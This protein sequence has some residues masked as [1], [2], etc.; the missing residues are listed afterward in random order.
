MAYNLNVFQWNCR[1]L[2]AN[3]AY[4]LEF[5]VNS[6]NTH[7]I[8]CL[9]SVNM[10]F[11]EL[12]RLE[13]YY[14][15]PAVSNKDK[16][17]RTVIYIH[18]Q[19]SYTHTKSPI[20]NTLEV[21]STAI[22][23]TINNKPHKI[24]SV[25]YPGGLSKP[26]HVDWL[27]TL[28]NN[29]GWIVLGDFNARHPTWEHG[30]TTPRPGGSLLL[31][32]ITDSDLV[33]LN[34]G[35]PTRL[36]DVAT[37][38]PTAIDLSLVS[39]SL[40]ID[41]HWS[42]LDDPL[43]S[44]HCPLLLTVE[45]EFSYQQT[46]NRTRFNYD[47]ADWV[48]FRN[49]L[50]QTSIDVEGNI[51]EAYQN[52][53]AAIL[54]A[55]GRAIPIL[56]NKTESTKL[57]P[58]W[59]D[60]CQAAVREKRKAYKVY[61]KHPNAGTFTLRKQAEATCD[62]TVAKAKLEYF[63][64]INEKVT[65]HRGLTQAWKRLKAVKRRYLHCE[66]PLMHNGVRTKNNKE[67]AH[68]LAQ[69]F[70]KA[71]QSASLPKAEQNRR[72][73]KGEV[74]DPPAQNDLVFN[75]VLTKKELLTVLNNMKSVKKATGPDPISYLMLGNLPNYTVEKLL[76]F[77]QRCW[78]EGVIPQAWR[79]AEV[80]GIHKQGKSKKHPA[81]Y[82]PISLTPQ[83]GKA[84]ER[85]ITDRLN[86]FLE[87]YNIIPDCQAGFRKHRSCADHIVSLSTQ[88]KR[89]LARKRDVFATF[90][91]IKGAY[92]TVWHNK[93]LTKLVNIGVSGRMYVFIKNFLS[94][95][96][97]RV[98]V[99]NDVSQV[100]KVD[101]GVPQGSII[102]PTLFNIMLYD[103]TK[104]RLKSEKAL[105]A[106]DLA[107]WREVNGNERKHNYSMAVKT[108]QKDMDRIAAY[109]SHNGF[110]LSAEKTVFM[111]FS[112]KRS[113]SN[114]KPYMHL[115][116]TKIEESPKVKFLGVIFTKTLNWSP[117]VEHLTKKASLAL[118]LI[119]AAAHEKWLT[120]PKVLTTLVGALIRSRLLYGCEAYFNIPVSTMQ[121]L[122]RVEIRAL[123]AALNL[124]RYAR[125]D[126]VYKLLGWLPLDKEIK[127]RCANYIVRA[128]S[129][130]NPTQQTLA[131]TSHYYTMHRS[132]IKR[133]SPCLY[134]RTVNISEYSTT[135][136]SESGVCLTE[137][138]QPV[139]TTIPLW[140][141]EPPI[142]D[143]SLSETSKTH[144]PNILITKA[145][146]KISNMSHYMQIYTDGSKINNQVGSAFVLPQLGITKSYTLKSYHSIFT[147]ELWAL[148]MCLDYV[149]SMPCP[150]FKVAI[151]SDSKAAVLAIKH[152]SRPHTNMLSDIYNT[153]NQ[154]H[155]KGTETIIVWIPSHMG[156]A[157]ND[158]ADRAAKQAAIG[159]IGTPIDL[160][161]SPLEAKSNITR[162]IQSAWQTEIQSKHNTHTDYR[163]KLLYKAKPCLFRWLVPSRRRIVHRIVTDSVISKYAPVLCECGTNVNL[164]HVFS[165]CQT[166]FTAFATLRERFH[167]N[168]IQFNIE[169]CLSEGPNGWGPLEWTADAIH[170]S[171]YAFA[172]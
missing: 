32:T 122:A 15:P 39:A 154:I 41:S 168:N 44:D 151:F 69:T 61:L 129:A 37:H 2:K 30:L 70:A 140:E 133:V 25:Y 127:R 147:A 114:R 123:K 162:Y 21:Y 128:Q 144:Q 149:N 66:S 139:P 113:R 82:R 50:I 68:I 150:P 6:H 45:R 117:H 93:L 12:P 119:K 35:T 163:I 76:R 48:L 58:W 74:P 63:K 167:L 155:I 148:Y 83:L 43:R 62:H 14:Y 3:S 108:H 77:F 20:A 165:D 120:D 49:V 116:N 92:D 11:N 80:V 31:Q 8:L 23:I 28:D 153:H 132:N 56:G 170:M 17:V 121:A 54:N 34:D 47:K 112:R 157:G 91:D 86:Y 60:E 81:N 5:L 75:S 152:F 130:T 27:T 99:G 53:R 125:N 4:L 65:D 55:A 146:E 22:E 169:E 105:F 71:S 107:I 156:I 10:K 96:T 26:E 7:H 42:V 38:S 172:F 160:G 89:A 57:S 124:P 100:H 110:T 143:L 64:V 78:E 16:K 1:S 84:F 135:V 159:N 97:L 40:A 88:I 115:Y 166:M 109:M 138:V 29:L 101:M 111:N 134:T 18:K 51:E 103:F 9:Q 171:R 161:I 94:G 142:V 67:K 52:I 33:L 59:N 131:R 106:D 85:I 137:I 87:K 141:M 13:G 102:A 118:N 46:D 79:D 95:R 73:K 24:V 98:R 36:P 136:L 104:L 72:L 90:F 126:L 19:C 145:R 164:E 158:K